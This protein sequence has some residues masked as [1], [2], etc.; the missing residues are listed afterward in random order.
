MVDGTKGLGIGPVEAIVSQ[1]SIGTATIAYVVAGGVPGGDA[2]ALAPLVGF[3][4][5]LARVR[6]R[7]KDDVLDDVD[8]PDEQVATDGGV[9]GA[10]DEQVAEAL[11]EED[12]RG[13]V[14]R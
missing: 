4:W 7:R 1:L 8:E 5:V 10:T 6:E 2:I 14:D 11:S 13:E 9:D 3:A 12:L